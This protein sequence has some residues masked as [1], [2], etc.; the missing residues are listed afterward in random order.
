[1]Q[2]YYYKTT[3]QHIRNEIP[4]IKWSKFI[5]NIFPISNKQEAEDYIA[6]VKKQHHSANHSCFAYTYGTNINFDLFWAVE[7]T[8]DSFR[9]SDDWEPA[10]T[11]WKPILAQ[12][13]WHNLHNVLLIVTRYFWWTL[14]WIWW[15]IQAYSDCAKQTIL[16]TQHDKKIIEIELTQNFTI[17][18]EYSQISIIMHLLDKYNA[19]IIEQIDWNTA[20]I[21]FQINKWYIDTFKKELSDQ[22]KWSI[23]I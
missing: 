4:K 16:T 2:K 8:A 11:A 18:I 20:Q 3:S 15:L 22:T 6:Q 12:I 17:N 7:I 5:G 14:L 1:M 19:K 21:K 13:Q 10:N 23:S 9:Q